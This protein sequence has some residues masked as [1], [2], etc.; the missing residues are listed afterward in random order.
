ML[1]CLVVRL[2]RQVNCALLSEDLATVLMTCEI[3]IVHQNLLVARSGLPGKLCVRRNPTLFPRARVGDAVK[4]CTALVG[5]H[6]LTS[7]ARMH[8]PLSF[9]H[10]QVT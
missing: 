2:G 3:Q 9:W 6:G 4:R 10:T 8:A 7:H 5:Q 1:A